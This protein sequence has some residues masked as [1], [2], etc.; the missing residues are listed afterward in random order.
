MTTG[1]YLVTPRSD[2]FLSLAR[3]SSKR[4]TERKGQQPWG[5]ARIAAA[6]GDARGA[7]RGAA[8]PPTGA[9]RPHRPLPNGA[10]F[11]PGNSPAK[12]SVPSRPA[13]RRGA[14]LTR[15]SG[16]GLWKAP[17]RES[18]GALILADSAYPPTAGRSKELK[19]KTI[20][21]CGPFFFFN[22]NVL[23]TEVLISGLHCTW[24]TSLFTF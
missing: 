6:P 4:G 17:R 20:K 10:G 18:K 21:Y 16:G 22:I 24:Q 8:A 2:I 5:A 19:Y 7:E 12:A 1:L 9:G 14:F 3:T 23:I 13:A 11:S 15:G